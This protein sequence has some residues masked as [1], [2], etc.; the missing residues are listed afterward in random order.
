MK[1]FIANL[2]HAARNGETVKIG[3][4]KFSA[5]E[6]TRAASEIDALS[7]AFDE[8]MQ[9]C[10]EH[11]KSTGFPASFHAGNHGSTLEKCRAARALLDQ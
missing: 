6:L 4:G 8:L 11:F 7:T 3:G 1:T 10:E 5:E 2:K 9:K